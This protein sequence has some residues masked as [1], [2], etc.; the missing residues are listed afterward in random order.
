MEGALL[1]RDLSFPSRAG[2]PSR[3][4]EPRNGGG[5][6]LLTGQRGR[7]HP[8][9]SGGS[10]PS[11]GHHGG[12]PLL[13]ESPIVGAFSSQGHHGGSFFL[14]G[15]RWRAPFPHRKP[16]SGRLPLTGTPQRA[17][18]LTGT[19]WRAPPPHRAPHGGRVASQGHH[20]ERVP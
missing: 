9:A 10:G 6:R 11:R 12:S 7:R 1:R 17:R 3:G 8:A 16:Q 5:R 18:P 14:T 15:T 13:T 4:W 2:V 19:P 20:G